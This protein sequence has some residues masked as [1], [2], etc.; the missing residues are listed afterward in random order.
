[1]KSELGPHF[2]YEKEGLSGER[3]CG[4]EGLGVRK[5]NAERM[6]GL[7]W[8]LA[9]KEKRPRRVARKT[10]KVLTRRQR[11]VCQ[12]KSNNGTPSM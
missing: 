1:V 2:L 8:A 7:D 11:A 3:N 10:G 5:L 4:V 9:K 6:G 12:K